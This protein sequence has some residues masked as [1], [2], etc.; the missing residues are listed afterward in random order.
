MKKV[1]LSLVFC[2]A[3]TITFA[4]EVGVPHAHHG[5]VHGVFVFLQWVVLLTILILAGFNLYK[6][7][8]H[9]NQA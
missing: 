8:Q 7:F 2:L 4:H 9:T 6:H 1:L 3:V 5:E